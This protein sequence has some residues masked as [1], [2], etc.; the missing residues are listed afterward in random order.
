MKMQTVAFVKGL[1]IFFKSRKKL[2]DS[3]NLIYNAFLK[4]EVWLPEVWVRSFWNIK[5]NLKKIDFQHI[6]V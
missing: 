2:N 5:L 1:S 4:F 3:W 6:K